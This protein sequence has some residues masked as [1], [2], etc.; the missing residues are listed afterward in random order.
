MVVLD[1][2]LV[3]FLVVLFVCDWEDAAAKFGFIIERES[4]EGKGSKF[5]ESRSA[6][7]VIDRIY[8]IF[9]D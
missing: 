8:K 5:I 9:Q 7:A 1:I 2:S 4:R 3:I 6:E